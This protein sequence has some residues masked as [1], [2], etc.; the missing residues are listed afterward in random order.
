[1]SLEPNWIVCGVRGEGRELRGR[2]RRLRGAGLRIRPYK[3]VLLF[4]HG[5]LNNVCMVGLSYLEL[6]GFRKGPGLGKYYSACY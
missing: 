3:H 5:V 6:Q 1:M 4:K 2:V